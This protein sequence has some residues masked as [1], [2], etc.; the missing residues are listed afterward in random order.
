MRTANPGAAL[1]HSAH[2]HLKPT[3][4]DEDIE[5]VARENAAIRIQRAWRGKR[6]RAHLGTDFLWTDLVTH[7]RFQ[8]RIMPIA[9][10]H[11]L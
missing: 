10:H 11:V 8:V 4:T 9:A 3:L 6:R 7:A 2:A 1:K 5:T